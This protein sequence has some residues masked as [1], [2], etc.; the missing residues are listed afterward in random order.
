MIER[1]EQK[2]VTWI[3]VV[4]PTSE[5][6]REIVNECDLPAEF[7]GDLTSTT[8]RTESVAT[9]NIVKI[10]IDIPVVK[11][12]DV[13]HAHEIKLIATKDR[14]ITIHFEEIEALHRFSKEFEV[15]TTLGNGNKLDGGHLFLTMLHHLYKSLNL[16]LDYL[17][18]R[19][20]DIE[21]NIFDDNNEKEM[22]FEISIIS[23]R[24]I[25][26]KHIVSV[27]DKALQSLETDMATAFGK[28]YATRV[29][30]I[31]VTYDQVLAR[32]RTLSSTLDDLRD[33]NGIL[34]TAK[35]NEVMKI[36]TIMAFITFPLTL[37]TSMFGMNTTTTPILG[38]SNDFWI[39]TGI[40]VVV[41]I[42]FFGFFKYKHWM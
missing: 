2:K 30:D 20:Q 33:T 11:R 34:L 8:P 15:V 23:R 13:A 17:E 36:L 14:L 24:L 21:E 10:T 31:R 1:L 39:I 40:M 42:G 32:V 41:S 19:M 7:V 35:Q 5:E 4:K 6:I 29:E 18:S 12:T 25:A 16:K 27:H 3:D 9:K 26:F 38:H 28:A 37:F 22:L